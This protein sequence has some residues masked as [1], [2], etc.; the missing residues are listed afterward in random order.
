MGTNPAHFSNAGDGKAAVARLVTDN[1]PVENVSWDDAVAFC[2]ELTKKDHAAGLLPEEWQYTLPSEQQWEYA[3]RAGT[4]TAT[5]FGNTL[6]SRQANFDGRH[7]L[8]I[9]SPGPYLER[10]CEVGS[11]GANPWGLNDMH[12]NVWEWC[13]DE[14]VDPPPG[15]TSTQQS[16]RP[17]V[18]SAAVAGTA[19]A[20]T[21]APISGPATRRTLAVALLASVHAP[22]E[23]CE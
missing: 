6:S 8:D 5:A 19:S 12:G 22:G 1:L 10:T 15:R 13:L 18:L 21:A 23:L 20:N 4:T 7:P 14:Y 2:R 11:Y 3:C 16:G 17:S 9:S